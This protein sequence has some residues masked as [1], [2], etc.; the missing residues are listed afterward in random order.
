MSTPETDSSPGHADAPPLRHTRSA[1]P[2]AI[3]D[4]A[5]LDDLLS[6]P[7]PGVVETC[8]R[9]KGDIV[10]LGVGGKMGPSLARMLRRASE[11]A[12]VPRRIVGV[13]RFGG[14]GASRSGGGTSKLREQL[15]NRGIETVACDLLDQDALG[16][17]PDADNVVYM[18]GMKFGSTG[19]Q[20]LTWA[21][22]SYLP[23]MVCR[24]YRRSRIVAFSTGNVYAMTPV[25]DG[26]ADEQGEVAP[27]GEYG[28]STL[29]R[30]RIFEHFSRTLDI[31][32]AVIRLNYAVE[33]RYGVLA[34]L[35]RKVWA[36]EPIDVTMGAFN[37]IWQAD[38][39]AQAIQAFDHA[40]SPPRVL[41]VTGPET[42]GVRSVCREFGRLMDREPRFVGAEADTALLNNA[43]LGHWLF[44]YPRVPILQVI[45][46]TA[47][48]VMAGGASLGKP[49]KFE[50]RDGKF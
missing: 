14:S 28:M 30:E 50:A 36:D 16:A 11:A 12:G 21:M 8:G 31:P 45:G 3:R 43:R 48:W 32:V 29:G 2:A 40:A 39:N 41:N 37:A 26:G 7:T 5:H 18:A 13:S 49:T 19:Q 6:E 15:E 9:L 24:R 10:V 27:V 25:A 20:A 4:E 47:D 17:L 33:M 22:N 46:W 23:G 38:A 42:L 34:D 44:G 35:A 1:P